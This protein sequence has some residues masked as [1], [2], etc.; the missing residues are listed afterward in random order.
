[1]KRIKQR[2][3]VIKHFQEEAPD[4]I[5][6]EH[7]HSKLAKEYLSRWYIWSEAKCI[8]CHKSLLPQKD[9]DAIVALITQGCKDSD[10]H[11]DYIKGPGK[12]EYGPHDSSGLQAP[13]TA[14]FSWTSLLD[15]SGDKNKETKKPATKTRFS[16]RSLK[17]LWPFKKKNPQD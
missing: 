14:H 16:W 12:S 7:C 1:V 8:L 11:K 13:P 6:C 17:N 15:D 10:E 2:D 3:A 5:V 4:F 9:Y